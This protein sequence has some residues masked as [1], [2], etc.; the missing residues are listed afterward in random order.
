M[1]NHIFNQTDAIT[2]RL[3]LFYEQKNA[4]I[5]SLRSSNHFSQDADIRVLWLPLEGVKGKFIING[6]GYRFFYEANHTGKVIKYIMSKTMRTG[7]VQYV[8]TK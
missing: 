7:V 8:T 3:K 1:K 6:I 4:I 2:N 5:A